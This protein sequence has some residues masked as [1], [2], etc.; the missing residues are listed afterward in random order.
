MTSDSLKLPKYG[1]ASPH[2]AKLLEMR[3]QIDQML[4]SELDAPPV[5][6]PS[7]S[8]AWMRMSEFARTH[9]YSAKTVSQWVR[10]GMPHIGKRHHCRVNVRAAET[11]IAEDGPTKA[12]KAMGMLAHAKEFG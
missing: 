10:L 9:H 6:Q 5:S 2:R 1:G 11:W 3:A 4:G 12:A 7:P 8:R